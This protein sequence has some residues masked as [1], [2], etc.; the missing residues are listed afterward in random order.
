MFNLPISPAVFVVY[1][2]NPKHAIQKYQYF[3][4]VL[5]FV[6]EREKSESLLI[7]LLTQKAGTRRT[8]GEGLLLQRTRSYQHCSV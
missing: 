3:C 6:V 4:C 2:S 7:K 8:T 1:P 5:C